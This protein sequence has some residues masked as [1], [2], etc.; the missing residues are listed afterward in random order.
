MGILACFEYSA[1]LRVY[2]SRPLITANGSLTSQ[3]LGLPAK[4][5]EGN[6]L[7]FEYVNFRYSG[8]D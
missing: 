8:V 2:G 4:Q 6:T 5:C 3:G 7:R 1:N